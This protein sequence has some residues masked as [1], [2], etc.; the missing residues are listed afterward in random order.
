MDG[1]Y[2]SAKAREV[3][4]GISAHALK[5]YVKSGK[6][7][8][9]VPPG[10]VL[11]YYPIPEVEALAEENAAFYDGKPIIGKEKPKGGGSIHSKTGS[12]NSKS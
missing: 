5:D 2:T 9:K 7:T 8:R 12:S 10:K 11:G 3:L 6:L 1:Y 4:G